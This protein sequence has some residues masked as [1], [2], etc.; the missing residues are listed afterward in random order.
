MGGVAVPHISPSQIKG[1]KFFLPLPSIQQKIASILSAYDDLIENNLKRIKLLEETAQRTYEEWFVK[2]DIPEDW[3]M[4]KVG[5]LLAKMQSTKKINTTEYK[6]IGQVPI[7][8]QGKD[9]IAGYTDDE[10][11]II[12]SELPIIVFGDHTRILKFIN[13][14]FARG[15]DGT[16]LIKSSDSKRMPQHLFFQSLLNV[17]LSNYH[18]ARHFKFLKELEII[19]PDQ[20]IAQQ[21]E[22]FVKPQ[23]DLISNFTKQNRLFKEARDILLPGL[24]TGV[25]S[26]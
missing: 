22:N 7:I 8:D 6:S 10:D 3:S 24:L 16:Q 25:I 17:D 15:A 1:Y 23:Y 2:D 26:V 9:F 13:F 11:A 5:D 14:S 12:S 21:F 20:K 18:Y 4:I 19:L